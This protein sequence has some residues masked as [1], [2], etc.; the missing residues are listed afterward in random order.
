MSKKSS[1]QPSIV[2]VRRQPVSQIIPEEQK[3]NV[4]Q[5][6]DSLANNPKQL[7]PR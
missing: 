4:Y 3:L 1:I 5:Q 7:D 2:Q 6:T